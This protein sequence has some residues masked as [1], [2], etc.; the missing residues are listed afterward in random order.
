MFKITGAKD[1]GR[2]D[3]MVSHAAGEIYTLEINAVPGLKRESLMPRAAE[4][5]GIAYEEMVEDILLS[6]W[7]SREG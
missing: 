6:A 1:V 5:F 7:N 4:Y 3:F 2:V